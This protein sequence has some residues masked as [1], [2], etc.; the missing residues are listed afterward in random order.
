MVYT[1][2]ERMEETPCESCLVSLPTGLG[3]VWRERIRFRHS[4]T[5]LR[6]E[7]YEHARSIRPSCLVRLF[8]LAPRSR[9][10][11]GSRHPRVGTMTARGPRPYEACPSLPSARVLSHAG[12]RLRAPVA[13]GAT[14]TAAAQ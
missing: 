1:V 8:D 6:K 10:R 12:A 3:I 2:C 4:G 7:R 11:P 14:A 5:Q 9:A 13:R